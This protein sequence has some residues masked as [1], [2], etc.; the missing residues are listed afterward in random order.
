MVWSTCDVRGSS[1]REDQRS[2]QLLWL[3]RQHSFRVIEETC[4]LRLNLWTP[5]S[6][7]QPQSGTLDAAHTN[8]QIEYRL[9][10]LPDTTAAA[11]LSHA[12]V[13]NELSTHA[14]DWS[15]VCF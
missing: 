2:V 5:Q 4:E 13:S 9:S 1:Q 15:A 7:D 3:G 12:F 11:Y 8:T 6:R 14:S 10:A